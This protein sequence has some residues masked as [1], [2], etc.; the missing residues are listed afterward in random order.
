MQQTLLT[1]CFGS[2]PDGRVQALDL[3]VLTLS[4]GLG[5]Y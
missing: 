3:P 4:A 1:D 2:I 5:F